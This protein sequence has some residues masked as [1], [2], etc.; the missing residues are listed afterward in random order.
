MY[1][2]CVVFEV[3]QLQPYAHLSKLH[4]ELSHLLEH[5]SASR[6]LDEHARWELSA[7]RRRARWH[8]RAHHR[9]RRRV[10]VLRR[11]LVRR[12]G[13]EVP[14]AGGLVPS[15]SGLECRE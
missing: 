1:C 6:H 9:P 15:A 10:R 5:V 4:K 3:V 12:D 13:K 14:P 2:I 7:P 11:G 8:R